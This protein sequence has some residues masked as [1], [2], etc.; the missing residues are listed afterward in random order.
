M[1]RKNRLGR[2]LA[3][4]FA[5]A[6]MLFQGTCSSEFD[7]SGL[8]GAATQAQISTLFADLVFFLLDNAF[9]RLNT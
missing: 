4:A 7:L 2:K 6:G 5:S 3:L 9:V 8:L 1:L